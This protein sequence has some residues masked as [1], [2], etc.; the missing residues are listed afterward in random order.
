MRHDLPT[1][2]MLRKSQPEPMLHENMYKVHPLITGLFPH[3]SE[4]GENEGWFTA[5]RKDAPL[6]N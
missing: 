1:C 6:K 2:E 4:M 5:N 3:V